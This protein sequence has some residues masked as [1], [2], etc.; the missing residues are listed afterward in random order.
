MDR[1]RAIL[2]LIAIS[3]ICQSGI[4]LV[5]AREDIVPGSRYTS[6]RAAA[7][8]D[9]F[10]P[11]ADDA[12]SALFYNPAGIALLRRPQFE[13]FNFQLQ[14]NSGLTSTFG[15]QS[16]KVTSL[17]GMQPTLS[18]NPRAFP[19]VGFGFLPTLAAPGLAFGVLAQSSVAG[20]N[21]GNGN[22]R[23][24]GL[25][26]IIPTA[27]GALSLARGI[28]R[29][30]YSLQWVHQSKGDR[31]VPSTTDPLGYNQQLQQGSGLSHN[32]GY[33][34]TLP[35][36]MLPSFN[37]VARNIGGVRYGATS[38]TSMFTENPSGTP[39]DE[40]MSVDASFSLH[41]KT[42][43]GG[44][45]HLV[46]QGRDLTNRSGMPI[47]GRLS[48]GFEWEFRG[49]V[50]L[51]LGFRSGYPSAGLGL[52]RVKARFSLSWYSEEIGSGYHSERETRYILHYQIRAF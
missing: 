14:A 17:S 7:M 47:L 25:Y 43:K 21:D 2:P 19:G 12:A 29:I 45:I 20:Q 22:I 13:P 37:V 50:A 38:L 27:G 40:E 28:I 15:T 49:I 51:R 8:G 35:F 10:L 41:P 26:Q 33:A 6:G 3:M 36:Q 31:T 18:E 39:D 16:Y 48:T 11:L 34:M 32:F 4:S 1:K 42:G 30:G 52:G 23:Y 9:A 24:R 5:F 46:F 44:Q